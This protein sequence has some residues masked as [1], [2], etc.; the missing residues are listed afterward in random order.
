[1][2]RRREPYKPEIEPLHIVECINGDFIDEVARITLS[3]P[4]EGEVYTVRSVVN[5]QNGEIGLLLVEM[6]NPLVLTE[7]G[8][9]QQRVIE[10]TFNSKRFRVIGHYAHIINLFENPDVEYGNY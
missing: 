2:S 7:V 9:N 10:T 4:I 1:M 3:L 5:Y 8:P 6:I